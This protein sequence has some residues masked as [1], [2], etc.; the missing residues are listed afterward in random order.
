MKMI[1]YQLPW[2]NACSSPFNS[3]A[4]GAAIS[5]LGVIPALG[6]LWATSEGA[7]Q[8]DFDALEN[9]QGYRLRFEF[10][11]IESGAI[12]LSLEDSLLSLTVRPSADDD[13]RKGRIVALKIPADVDQRQIEARLSDGMLVIELGKVEA[14]RARK[15]DVK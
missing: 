8:R 10:P 12:G 7:A 1:R 3:F 13:D 2:A 14:V 4:R 9:E 11:G 15:I 5:P 6:D